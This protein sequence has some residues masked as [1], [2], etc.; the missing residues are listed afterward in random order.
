MTD[1]NRQY[2]VMTGG[3]TTK[4]E[5]HIIQA[6][7]NNTPAAPATA[8][9][10]YTSPEQCSLRRRRWPAYLQGR[11]PL[12]L[13]AGVGR[14]TFKAGS[15]SPLRVRSDGGFLSEERRDSLAG[16][17]EEFGDGFDGESM[18]SESEG[19]G[20]SEL[21]AGGLQGGHVG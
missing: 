3:E 15:L 5:H 1:D 17:T 19:F 20:G 11:Q 13:V 6:W 2:P 14:P 8:T 10:T 21:G 18:G 4:Q 9:R 12:A 7:L 16:D